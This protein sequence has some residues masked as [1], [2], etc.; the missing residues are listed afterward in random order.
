MALDD[1]KGQQLAADIAHQL[2]GQSKEA[3]RAPGYCCIVSAP[4]MRGEGMYQYIS[5]GIKTTTSSLQ[6][7][8]V[9]RR[10]SDFDTLRTK[11]C[12]MYHGVLVPPL[13]DKQVIGRLTNGRF[14]GDFLSERR[15]GLERF[16]TR[17]ASHSRLCET[18][19][20]EVFL[21]ASAQEWAAAKLEE[22]TASIQAEQP[23]ER[24]FFDT[25]REWTT[26]V[27]VGMGVSAERGKTE[28]DIVCEELKQYTQELEKALLHVEGM[29]R[30]MTTSHK[31]LS[32][33]WFEL[34]VS[35]ALVGQQYQSGGDQMLTRVMEQVRGASDSTS[36]LFSEEGEL[37]SQ[38][39]R[40]YV[41]DFKRFSL[42]STELCKQRAARLLT[43]NT[44]ANTLDANQAALAQGKVSQAQLAAQEQKT[45]KAKADLQ[46]MTRLMLEEHIRFRAT[47]EKGL[48]TSIHSFARSQITTAKK[49]EKTWSNM[50]RALGG[51]DM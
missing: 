37:H 27:S 3:E 50:L 21:R 39:F 26:T 51:G 1:S 9:D 4:E 44:E 46:Q 2:N 30:N 22:K 17:V 29:S 36:L 23:Q 40:E 41:A 7:F 20:V 38:K 14:N 10:Y 35:S 13:P 49:A 6:E 32:K 11:L 33:A 34:S 8:Q 12:S 25:F 28:D 43:Y 48:S 42:A 19:E 16:L 18:K 31:A 24:S 15:R 45:D 47:K 5:Y